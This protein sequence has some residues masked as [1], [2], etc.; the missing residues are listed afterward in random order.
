MVQE[1]QE[2]GTRGIEV[3]GKLDEYMHAG[4]IAGAEP[5]PH[6]HSLLNSRNPVLLSKWLSRLSLSLP[7][8]PCFIP[9]QV[10][11]FPLAATARPFPF[12][13][14]PST[15]LFCQSLLAVLAAVKSA[16]SKPGTVHHFWHD[17]INGRARHMAAWLQAAK[18]Y[19]ELGREEVLGKLR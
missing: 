9:S 6:S 14:F 5:L 19:R 1:T 4:S 17:R 2:K 7:L 16:L 10:R 15:P 18:R 13:P 8:V 12:H 3:E 11:C